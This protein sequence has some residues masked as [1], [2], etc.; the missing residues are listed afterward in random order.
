M[1]IVFALPHLF[2]RVA[3]RFAAEGLDVPMAFG[4]RAASEQIQGTTRIVWTPGDA[5]GGL[6]AIGAARFPGQDPRR[7]LAQLLEAC[8]VD[9]FA[10]DPLLGA[11]ER[12]QYQAAR[13]LFDA[14]FRAVYLE[15]HGTFKITSATWA[16]GDRGRRM[17]ASI[18]VVFTVQAPIFD[19][20]TDAD[21]IPLDAAALDVA[22]SDHT[23]P[24]TVTA[25]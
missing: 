9:M 5:G 11:D 19:E 6:G 24:L 25:T 12:A 10:A 7:P 20:L 15:A 14:W 16:G 22:E 1:A 23:E 2:D 18:R 4:W 13:T 3:A 17:G 8:T 21:A